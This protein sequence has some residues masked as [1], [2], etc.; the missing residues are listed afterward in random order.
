MKHT[1]ICIFAL[2]LFWISADVFGDEKLD[3]VLKSGRVVDGTGAPWYV[4]DVG[5]RDG[6]IARIGRIPD[7]ATRRS[8]DAAGLF[9][10]PGFIDMMGQTAN[11]FLEDANSAFNLLTQGITTINAGEGASAAPLDPQSAQEAGWRTM[12][13]YFLL[14]EKSGIPLN[15]AQTVG[16]TQVRRI[17]LGEADHDVGEDQ[18]V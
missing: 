6:K 15:V 3:L 11:P 10:A 8:I 13:E 17:V 9:V 5:I 4:A 16:H 14:L 7:D 18:I 2:N 12:A 1:S